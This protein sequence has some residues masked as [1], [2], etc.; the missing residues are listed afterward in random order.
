MFDENITDKLLIK[1]VVLGITR[2]HLWKIR[3]RIRY[4]FESFPTGKNFRILKW[5]LLNHIFLLKKSHDKLSDIFEALECE[6]G[7]IFN[8]AM[9]VHS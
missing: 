4:D 6:I 9:Q 2:F 7:H 5:S 3:N 8:Q 1:N